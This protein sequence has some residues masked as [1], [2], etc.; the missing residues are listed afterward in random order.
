MTEEELLRVPREF[1]NAAVLIDD[2][3]YWG[4]STDEDA[5]EIVA[6]DEF[7]VTDT[8]Q[9]GEDEPSKASSSRIDAEKVVDGFSD[10]GLVCATYRWTE[11]H[12]VFP[13]SS[14]KADL[15]ILDWKLDNNEDVGTTAVEFLN[16]RLSQDLSGNRRLRY[17]VVYTDK[18][19]AGVIQK[20]VDDLV[21]PQGISL[22]AGENCVE[23][24]E[25]NGPSLWRILYQSKKTTAESDLAKSVLT[26]FANFLDGLLPRAVMSG[27]AELRNR[28]FEHLY[29]FNKAL[30]PVVASHLLAKRSSELEFPAASDAFS[31]FVIGLIVNDFSDALYGSELLNL[32]SS[33]NAVNHHMSQPNGV[34]LKF[35]QLLVDADVA[36]L[37]TLISEQEYTKFFSAAEAVFK[38][39]SE[40]ARKSFKSGRSPMEFSDVDVDQYAALSQID[41]MNN[42]PREVAGQFQLK[43]GV[44]VRKEGDAGEGRKYLVCIQ[45]ICDAVRLSVEDGAASR[46]PFIELQVVEPSKKFTFVVKVEDAYVFLLT[47][48]KVS[49][50][51]MASFTASPES[52]DIRTSGVADERAFTDIDGA[53]YR[54]ISE[55]KEIYAIELQNTLSSQ[56]SRIGSNKFEWLRTRSG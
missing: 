50:V 18:P 19:M 33:A 22:A 55:L 3:L 29:R 56:A 25:E 5:T 44:I 2:E 38:L 24:K 40:K 26:D 17:I 12:S 4:Q 45:P 43:S 6:P 23:V 20:L 31:E 28:T 11:K 53:N 52:R 7:D 48:H 34:K 35:N 32:T 47:K 15:I 27:V 54:W 1:L 46:F 42:Y 13:N 16:N 49:E 10:L 30:D 14:D 21:V 8:R 41:L 9:K 39:N 37:S 36:Q 51:L